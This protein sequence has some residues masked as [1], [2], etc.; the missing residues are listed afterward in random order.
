MLCVIIVSIMFTVI[1]HSEY[2]KNV[3]LQHGTV[4]ICNLEIVHNEFSLYQKVDKFGSLL[5]G[6]P[7]SS[8]LV[9]DHLPA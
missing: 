8:I 3:Q 4:R 2:T 6:D 9:R 7:C 5:T 1:H